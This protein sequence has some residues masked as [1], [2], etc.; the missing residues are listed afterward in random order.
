M[1]FTA[2]LLNPEEEPLEYLNSEELELTETSEI[3]ELRTI[4]LTYPLGDDIHTTRENFKIGNKLWIPGGNGLEP[5]LYI[6]TSQAKIDYWQ[7]NNVEAEFEEILVQLNYVLF[8][9]LPNEKVTLV[10]TS[11]GEYVSTFLT[12]VFED[13]FEIRKVEPPVSNYKNKIAINGTM[14]K[15]ELLRYIEEETS[16]VFVTEYEK[17]EHSNTIKCYLSFLQPDHVGEEKDS[18][19][20]LSFNAE[21]IEFEL[22]ESDTYKAIGPLFSLDNSS[23]NNELTHEDLDIL[24]NGKEY[25]E[26]YYEGWYPLAVTKGQQIPMIIEKRKVTGSNFQDALNSLGTY[27]LSTNYFARPLHPSDNT[28]SSPKSYEFLVATAYWS[29]PFTKKANTLYVEDDI[30][31][32]VQYTE[33]HPQKSSEAAVLPKSGTIETSETNPYIIYNHCANTLL[34]KRYSNVN[35]EVDLRDIEQITTGNTGF[36]LY[37]IV[38]V[39]VPD[40]DKPIKAQVVSVE[41]N[42]QLPGE[43]KIVL[44][45]ANIG[46]RINQEA[47]TMTNTGPTTIKYK[48]GTVKAKLRQKSDNSPLVKRACTIFVHRDEV[49][50]TQNMKVTT[51]TVTQVKGN[52]TT[53]K[54]YENGKL[55]KTVKK[56]KSGNKITTYTTKDGKTTTSVSKTDGTTVT[57]NPLDRDVSVKKGVSKATKSTRVGSGKKSNNPAD[58]PL[59]TVT[60]KVGGIHSSA[61]STSKTYTKTWRNW[62]PIC[63]RIGGLAVNPKHVDECEL[64]CVCDADYDCVTGLEKLTNPHGALRDAAGKYNTK[65]NMSTSV[66]NKRYDTAATAKDTVTT[67]SNTKTK[68]VTTTIPAFNKTYN[69]TTNSNGE[70]SLKL[71]LPKGDY[72]VTFRYGGSIEYGASSRKINLKVT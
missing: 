12:D 69:R 39:K 58:A 3:K 17:D 65:N 25:G 47:T 67:K 33:V 5:C 15:L 43:N 35:L 41:K 48:G 22:E 26:K 52:T 56:V 31:T 13:Y 53:V 64:T 1:S 23:G 46:A 24:I 54:T 19:I 4:H 2:L 28:D 20:D 38:Q 16:N 44:G 21:N 59:L 30:D 50:Y 72:T 27:N 55:V 29:A 32:E 18:L 68:P 9:Q 57:K 45:N 14:T 70:I 61:Y 60:G 49:K 6:N 66:G 36:N 51:K 10:T 42:P 40:F 7:D 8:K 71:K 62:C 34:D 11:N 63:H 37:D